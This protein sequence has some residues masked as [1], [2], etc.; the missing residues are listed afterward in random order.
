[1]TRSAS[2]EDHRRF[3]VAII[4]MAGRAPG[5]RNLDEFWRNVRDG[6][7]SIAVLSE[8]ELVAAGVA[9]LVFKDPRYV[10]AWGVL[11]DAESF[12]ASFFGFSPKE[13]E[14][15]DPQHR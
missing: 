11:A 10:R 14:I 3:E 2:S 1:M 7:E 9:P 8:A 6:M 5:A 12:D 13:A 15:M 4:G